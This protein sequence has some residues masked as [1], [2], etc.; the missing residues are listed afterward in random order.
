MFLMPVRSVSTFGVT[1]ESGF[2]TES[3]FGFS[4]ARLPK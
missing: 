2:E 3:V 4:I 1:V